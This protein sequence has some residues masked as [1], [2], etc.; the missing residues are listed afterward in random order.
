MAQADRSRARAQR[1]ARAGKREMCQA[2]WKPAPVVIS[3]GYF[4]H[5]PHT[6]ISFVLFMMLAASLLSA[7]NHGQSEQV[8]TRQAMIE[9]FQD[10]EIV[11]HNGGFLM[12]DKFPELRWEQPFL[13]DSLWGRVPLTVR[14][15][16]AN[17]QEAKSPRGPGRYAAY[18]EV[19]PKNGPVIRRARTFYAFDPAV[20]AAMFQSPP[21][22]MPKVSLPGFAPEA[23]KAHGEEINQWFS[24]STLTT[25][26]EHERAAILIASAAEWDGDAPMAGVS[27]VADM[28]H[29]EHHL[30]I[31]RRILGIER[32]YPPLEP[33]P[34]ADKLSPVLT[35]GS[36]AAAGFASDLPARLREFAEQW[37]E[38]AG[39]PFTLVVARRGVIVFHEAIGQRTGEPVTRD[40][41]YGMFSIS[42]CVT[43]LMLMHLLDRGLLNLD[44]PLGDVLP[45]LP[46]DGPGVITLRHCMMHTSGLSGH[47]R[48]DSLNNPWL[49]NVIANGMESHR[50]A[51]RYSGVAFDLAGMAMQLVTAKSMPR[52]FRDH[53]F[54]PLEFKNA[55]VVEL[56]SGVHLRAIDLARLGQVILNRGRYGNYILY[57]EQS[58]D[59]FLPVPY[60]TYFPGL[61]PNT[62]D[63]GLGIRMASEPHPHAG[64]NGI[65]E[66][67]VIPSP[68]TVGH[69]AFG[70]SIFRVDLEHDIVITMGRFSSGDDY[71]QHLR[72][73]LLIV[74]EAIVD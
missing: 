63:Y 8:W 26:L 67:A 9:A 53:L 39:E 72:R 56:G 16:D 31:K 35:E 23:W 2:P 18:I 62:G 43:G 61:A 52:L 22:E 51:Y 12:V 55:K 54:E 66:D 1:N 33:R 65:P 19:R 60:E 71:S 10:L 20:A 74:T 7:T 15:F 45:D 4:L 49:D 14:W 42:K 46:R 36:P 50:P 25:L 13:V 11:P 28:R 21:L 17:G 24:R 73:L 34:S 30:A 68:R 41:A 64:E 58:A 48:W 29:Q 47:G 5:L 37:H 38:Q 27:N 40:T 57:R 6:A 59:L 3:V 70:G 32:K 44:A 69:G